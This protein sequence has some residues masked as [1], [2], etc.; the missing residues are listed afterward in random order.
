LKDPE[1]DYEGVQIGTTPPFTELHAR[2]NHAVIN[3]TQSFTIVNQTVFSE[4]TQFMITSETFSWR[5]SSSNLRVQALK[6]PVAKGISFDKR[7]DLKGEF[8]ERLDYSYT[9]RL[10]GIN[11]FNGNIQ[12]VDFILPSD[13]PAG[14]INFEAVTRLN[15][16]RFVHDGHHF[17]DFA[18]Q[19]RGIVLS[20]LSLARQCSTSITMEFFLESGRRSIQ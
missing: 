13:N 9:Y 4:F 12:L 15:N 11:N 19:L 8:V 6:F 10:P 7:I 18:I 14:G 20:L 16:A 5:L 17:P 2:Q 3:Q 1:H